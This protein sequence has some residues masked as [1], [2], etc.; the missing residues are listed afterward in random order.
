[1]KMKE[2]AGARA[3]KSTNRA[4]F[5]AFGSGVSI[6]KDF[7]FLHFSTLLTENIFIS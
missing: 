6:F 1:M 7:D 2:V 4:L 3:R 5:Q